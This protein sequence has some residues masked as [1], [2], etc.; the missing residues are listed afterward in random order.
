MIFTPLSGDAS[1]SSSVPLAY[2]LQI[3]DV[4]VLLDCGSP[5]WCPEPGRVSSE[6]SGLAEEEAWEKYCQAL[7]REAPTI[8]LV[9]L[10]HG[11][12]AHVGLYAYAYTHWG[13]RA[14]TYSSLPVQAMGKMAVLEE[15]G[16]LRSEQDIDKEVDG[17]TEGSDSMDTH[18][19]N[20]AELAVKI[21]VKGKRIATVDQVQ[22]AFD[23]LITLRYSEPTLLSGKCQ[24]LTITP[25]SS[26]HSLGGTLWKIRSPSSGTILYAVNLNHMKERH[27]D[28]TV[29]IK[30]GGGVFEPLARPDLLITDAER[31][32]V[33]SPRRKDRDA[34]LLDIITTT[35]RSN[36]SLLLPCDAS[37]RLLELLILLDQHWSFSKIKAPICLISRTG[38]EM[39]GLARSML[40][41]MGGTVG[42]DEL[43]GVDDSRGKRRRDDDEDHI[44]SVA[45]RFR[46]LEFYSSPAALVETYPSSKPKLILSVPDNLSYGSSRSLFADF[47][48]VPGNVV[49]LTARGGEP[50]SL[51]AI[52]FSKWNAGQS[53]EERFGKGRVGSLVE[54]NEGLH[55]KMHS[56]VP[57][58]GAELEAYLAHERAEQEKV[59]AQQAALAR[60][61]RILEADEGS[62]SEDSDSGAEDEDEEDDSMAVDDQG[63]NKDSKG[64][65][66]VTFAKS[67]AGGRAGGNDGQDWALMDSE[68]GQT[69]QQQLSFDIYLKGNV[70]RATSF[71]KS[72]ATPG[73]SLTR[74]RM[75]PYIERKRRVDA[76]GE[77]ID[78]AAW[79]RKGKVLEEEGES[80]E[81]K[82]AKKR[83]AAEEEAKVTPP[84]P[85]SK[86]I[87]EEI[88]IRLACKLFYV[89]LEGLNDG[90]AVKTIIPQV[91]PRK[92][93]LVHASPEATEALLTS[94]RSIRSMT[95]D[96]FAP[97]A[98]E[99]ITIGQNTTTF[100]ISLSDELLTSVKMSRFEDHEVGYIHGRVT[101]HPSS[102]IPILEPASPAAPLAIAPPVSQDPRSAHQHTRPIAPLPRST[103]IGDLKLTVL[104]TRLSAL[105]ISAEFA[106]E[107]VLV[108][109]VNS[110]EDIQDQVAVRKTG[111]GQVMLE[112]SVC[113][114]YY[115][116]RRE[117]YHLHALVAA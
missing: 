5:N 117:I 88:D 22:E 50:D 101:S 28:G 110:D 96:V 59:A 11:D 25:F 26:G 53:E 8:D 10:S 35:I 74:F 7:Q 45:L 23:S 99:S 55:L 106:G 43:T 57:L 90:R 82:E 12:L 80:E 52:L 33:V 83:R 91:N 15:I 30:S 78:V 89:D 65:R 84:E 14:P 56:K 4:R 108:C 67:G 100:A 113:N 34:A 48:S 87:T 102:T 94:C 92:M 75:F 32:M 69:R 13:L 29:L 68:E 93:I 1:T 61:Q 39:L 62:E 64:K 103:M 51:A 40:E 116:I 21:Q 27:L 3:D 77:T 41:W 54:L 42:R 114:T 38:R 115:T 72:A 73:Q 81:A 109:S 47:V 19:E 79:I 46:H 107:G 95:K 18:P 76:Y 111:K 97:A 60:N 66:R 85:P 70:S 20:S 112:G 98:G 9:L 86:F 63:E 24:G 104:K 17:A 36:H 2:I 71:F 44:G 16:T 49:V 31:A 105:G 6:D 58:Q 37:T